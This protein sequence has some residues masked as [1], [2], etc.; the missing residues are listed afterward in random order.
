LAQ[1]TPDPEYGD[2]PRWSSIHANK[3]NRQFDPSR[4][5]RSSLDAIHYQV[6][7][8]LVVSDAVA[9]DGREVYRRIEGGQRS[10][11]R[12]IRLVNAITSPV[13]SLTSKTCFLRW[14]LL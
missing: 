14:G 7:Q 2:T 12:P 4:P 10:Q 6:Q 11:V 3:P 8:N 9:Q 1:T 5:S 13:N